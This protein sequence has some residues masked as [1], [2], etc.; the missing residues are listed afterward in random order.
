MRATSPID[1]KPEQMHITHCA[2]G[3]KPSEAGSTPA[4]AA[5][6]GIVGPNMLQTIPKTNWE[7]K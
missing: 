5:S 6:H 7:A 1:A 4:C 2:A 3:N